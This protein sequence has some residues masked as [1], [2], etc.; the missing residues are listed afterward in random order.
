MAH[1]KSAAKKISILMTRISAAT[2]NTPP[3]ATSRCSV[4]HMSPLTFVEMAVAVA[5]LVAMVVAVVV[6]VVVVVVVWWWL[7]RWLWG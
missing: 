3:A 5:C 2:I 7:G 4:I 6:V 1:S